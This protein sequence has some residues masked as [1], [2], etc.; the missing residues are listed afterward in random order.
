MTAGLLLP[1]AV[2]PWRDGGLLQQARSSQ[3]RGDGE[4]SLRQFIT[5][6]YPR[7]GFHRWAVVLI[8]LLQAVADGQLNRLIVTCPPRLGKSLLVS[9]LFPAYFLQRYPHLFAAIASYSAELAYARASGGAASRRG[10]MARS[11]ARATAWGSS[12]TRTRAPVMP[13]PRHSGRS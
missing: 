8:E 5:E 7:Y 11:R 12:M 3:S 6:A 2:D 13:H 9:K 10:W 4:R 1:P